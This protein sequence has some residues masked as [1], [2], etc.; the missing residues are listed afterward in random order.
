MG[1]LFEIQ[2]VII[3]QVESEPFFWR[4]QFDEFVAFPHVCGILGARRMGKT[5][6]LL[7]QAIATRS[8]QKRGSLCFC[9]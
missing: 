4:S 2:R 6:F 5:T 1:P 9:R 7:R 3:E 8:Q